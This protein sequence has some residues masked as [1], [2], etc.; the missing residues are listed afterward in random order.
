MISAVT[1]SEDRIDSEERVLLFHNVPSPYRLPVFEQLAT[2]CDLEVVFLR[3]NEDYRKW[4]TD[5][6]KFDFNYK[7]LPNV[8]FGPFVV[9]Y[10][11]L[12]E[13]LHGKYDTYVIGD[14]KHGLLTTLIAVLFGKLTGVNIVLWSGWLSTDFSTRVKA[15]GPIRGSATKVYRMVRDSLQKVLYPLADGFL[16]YSSLTTQYLVKRG[17]DTDSIV[18]GGQVMPAENLP[19]STDAAEPENIVLSLGYLQR[20]KGIDILLDAWEF[21][22]I[23]DW[24]LVIAGSGSY[25]DQIRARAKEDDTVKFEGY[26]Q[27]TE[28]A[29]LYRSAR[30]FVLPTLHDPWGLVINEAVYYDTPVIT[31]QFAGASDFVEDSRCGVVVR[32]DDPEALADALEMMMMND[33]EHRTEYRQQASSSTGL[34]EI[35]E[36]VDAILEAIER[37]K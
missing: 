36:S 25:E 26:V 4:D 5:L 30:V 10:T 24:N 22:D 1:M 27:G 29:N 21:V 12:F 11:L 35:S 13:L 6:N 20:R 19:S 31:T 7:F 18:E 17:A 28:K 33:E 2:E 15:K 34:T 9:N 3:G 8:N 37:T 14:T 32:G 23:G 16:S